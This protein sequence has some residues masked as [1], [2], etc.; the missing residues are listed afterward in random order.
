MPQ[1]RKL[2]WCPLHKLCRNTESSPGA[3]FINY[4]AT[5]KAH[6]ATL[7]N[8]GAAVRLAAAAEMPNI[9]GDMLLLFDAFK[10]LASMMYGA[11]PSLAASLPS[12]HPSSCSPP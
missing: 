8:F 5:L 2:T 12:N 6:L 11:L 1:H 4:A 10:L 7:F 9:V 3:L